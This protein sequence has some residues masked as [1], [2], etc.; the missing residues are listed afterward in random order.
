LN[1]KRVTVPET[2]LVKVS[3]P[4]DIDVPGPHNLYVGATQQIPGKQGIAL[5]GN[6]KG[7]IRIMVPYPDEYA[8]VNLGV[9]NANAGKPVSIKLRIDSLGKKNITA[10]TVLYVYDSFNRSIANLPLGTKTI[11]SLKSEDIETQLNTQ[12]YAPGYYRLEAIVEYGG[13]K[14]PARDSK[15]F[16]LGELFVN[17]T[18][19]S[20]DFEKEQINRMDIGV[21]S[22]WNDPIQGVAANVSLLDY[23]IFFTTQAITLQPF[24]EGTLVGYLDTKG[25]NATKF[26]A[27][28]T[29][30]YEGKTT[31]KTVWLWFKKE[32]NN[33]VYYIGA[34]VILIVILITVLLFL[35]K[36]R[37]NAR[38]KKGR[39]KR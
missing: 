19:H 1:T 3:L 29:V 30:F 2:V 18:R 10:T 24:S 35:R 33:L 6:V 15:P 17:I 23:P 5:V 27:K 8:V 34:A 7:I 28:I 16:R 4:E 38:S 32:K 9:S 20:N 31:E 26:Q 37:K 21:E 36:G 11:A 13:T 14:G 22:F 12:G 39:K 25:I